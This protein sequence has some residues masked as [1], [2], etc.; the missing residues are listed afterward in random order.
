MRIVKPS[1]I[2]TSY[3]ANTMPRSSPFPRGATNVAAADLNNDGWIDAVYTAS[4]GTHIAWNK[5][6][7]FQSDS[8]A[9]GRSIGLRVR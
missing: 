4:T 8:P 9:H 1:C 3:K 2:A 6:G 5:N 7:V